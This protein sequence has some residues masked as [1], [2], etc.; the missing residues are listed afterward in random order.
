MIRLKAPL[1]GRE[2][3]REEASAPRENDAGAV[4][5]V[6]RLL[7]ALAWPVSVFAL[8]AVLAAVFLRLWASD[9]RLPFTHIGD[10]LFS[11]MAIKGVVDHGWFLTNPDVGAPFGQQL[12]D[13]AGVNGDTMT[14]LAV[15]VLA[16][17]T[18]DPSLI[19]NLMFVLS[20]PA[21]AL[22]AFLVLRALEIGAPAAAVAATL[23]ALAPYHFVRGEAHFFLALYYAVPLGGYLVMSV[24]G[25]RP[26]FG[27]R[28]SSSGPRLLAWASGRSLGTIAICVV[29]ASGG[30]YYAVFTVLLLLVAIVLRLL[31]GR[32]PAALAS[33][34]AVIATIGAVML[35]SQAPTLIYQSQHGANEL[36]GKRLA[37][38][39]E[40]YSLKLT[41]LVLPVAGH[42]V[43]A[44]AALSN[45]YSADATSSPGELPESLGL[46]TSLGFAWLL[47]V[48]LIGAVSARL[49]AAIDDRH[50]H[51][52]VAALFC[53]LLGTTGGL[54]SLIAY[55][56]SP[57][58][59]GWNRISIFIAFFAIVAVALLLD[60]LV[61]RLQGRRAGPVLVA[62]LLGAVLLGGLY[63]QTNRSFVPPY[64]ATKADYGSDRA[65]VA[66]IERQMPAGAEIFQMPY[67]P[68]P[69][70]PRIVE[71]PDQ[72]L[73]RP[74]IQS[75]DLRWSYGSMKGRPEDWVDDF[76]GLAEEQVAALTV[77]VS[78]DRPPQAD[79]AALAAAGFEGIYID[80][81]GYGDRAAA[82]EADL[83]RV[84]GAAPLVS[85]NGRM[86]F[87]SLLG[88]QRSLSSRLD[89]GERRRLAQAT[90]RPLVGSYGTGFY[91]PEPIPGGTARWAA[92][93]AELLIDNPGGS[94][95]ATFRAIIKTA[96]ERPSSITF[97]SSR[98]GVVTRSAGES[99]RRVTVRL[100]LTPGRNRIA[101]STDAPRTTS[102][103][104]DARVLFMR[105]ENPQIEDPA[106]IPPGLD[107]GAARPR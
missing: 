30:V 76:Y 54:S 71:L 24:F 29:V 72:D 90:L 9:M 88:T 100:A 79:V 40:V 43:H 87:F 93:A 12:H 45:R 17:F 11:L 84:T 91:P 19:Q 34:C 3:A 33:G 89:R 104:G 57:Q 38:E 5:P 74:Y 27:R 58:I 7:S 16:L 68:F 65:F 75:S 42:R 51:A 66:A 2:P 70:N 4:A 22:T 62:G 61:R 86:S 69:G 15:K 102:A 44:L 95:S 1:A 32:R 49:R 53:L 20:F 8:N 6:R 80:R 26:L 94:P 64:S 48:T 103:A 83:R 99:G 36:V 98:G 41:R 23:F 37:L 28:R 31:V 73:L 101:I 60:Q 85:P 77:P 13:F 97:S 47:L 52:A 92:S 67:T 55:L 10:E 50:G 35:A 105:F 63:D 21:I 107:A 106:R 96:G 56:I 18:V 14:I 78:S 46:V 25:G 81:F 82:L 39:S 59:R